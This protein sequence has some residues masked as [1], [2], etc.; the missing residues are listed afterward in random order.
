MKRYRIGR[1]DFDFGARFL[2]L[3]INPAWEPEHRAQQEANQQVIRQKVLAEYGVARSEEKL[4]NYIDVD[5]APLSI[6]AYHNRFLRQV[7]A[8]FIWSAYYPALTGA[9]ALGERL[10]NHLVIDLRD[11]FRSTPEYRK[12]YRKDSFDNWELAISVL[13]AWQI[14]AHEV[15]GLFRTLADIRH[16]SIHFTPELA[17]NDR[18]RSLTAIRTI[19]DI[20]ERQFGAFGSHQWFIADTPGTAF[21]RKDWETHPFVKLVYLPNCVLVTPYHNVERSPE[22][23]RVIE[24]CEVPDTEVSDT[25]FARLYRESH[26][27]P[28]PTDAV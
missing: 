7:R 23:W 13:E 3:P 5:V 11:S 14:L 21:I 15:A 6:I 8:S 17:M 10:L 2:A 28:F 12:V 22:G 25:E 20:V 18:E 1:M 27:Q 19:A 26:G 4:Q 9:C 16:R 24:P